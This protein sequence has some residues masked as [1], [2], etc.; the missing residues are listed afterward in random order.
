LLALVLVSLCLGR[1]Q[2][3]PLGNFTINHLAAIAPDG[4]RLRVHYVLDIAEIPAF[5]IMHG[6]GGWDAARM[7]AWARDEADVVLSDLSIQA[8]GT[9]VALH[10]LSQDA[11]T[12]PGAG[13]LPTL[14]WTGDF[15]SALPSAGSQIFVQDRVYA[16]RRIGWKDI[17]LPGF[18]DPTDALRSYPSALI[19]SPRHNDR[20][21][22]AL[23]ANGRIANASVTGEDAGNSSAASSIVRSSALSDLFSRADQT[24]W[25]VFLT[26]LAAF[27]LG[28]L[29]ALEPGHGKALL[30]FTLVGARATFKQAGILALALTVAH[31]FAVLLLGLVLFFAA[32][33]ATESL[34]TWITLISGAAIA[35]IGARSLANALRRVLPHAHGEAHSHSHDHAHGHS[36]DHDHGHDHAIPG[37]APLHFRSAVIAAMSGGIAP[38]PAA[39]VVLLTALH[40]HR[41]GYGLCLIVI[42]SLGL[43]A[44]LTGVGMAVVHG[45]AWLQKRSAFGRLSRLA[46]LL[47]AGVISLIGATMLAQG[48]VEQ[49]IRVPAFAVIALTLLAIGGFALAPK[50]HHHHEELNA[51]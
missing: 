34:F 19:G 27:G 13:G 20:A 12:R 42:F 47:S 3:H 37:T 39:I 17:V 50:H 11:V 49:G 26:V 24:P 9:P 40:L 23:A 28:A 51:A 8:N 15:E 16:D 31:T 18:S 30:A 45:A 35:I 6:A 10:L 22:F 48:F 2:A 41:V 43:A 4:D 5:Q 1:V 7:R 29:H 46:P 33:F 21:S 25:L 38:C 36:H 32:G 14:Y 44:V